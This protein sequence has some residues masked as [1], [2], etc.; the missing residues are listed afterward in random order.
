MYFIPED[1]LDLRVRE[2]KIP[3]DKWY[4]MGLIRLCRGNLIDPSDITAWFVEL[5]NDFEL[6]P[7]K[8]GY[9]RYSACHPFDRPALLSLLA[10]S[11][12]SLASSLS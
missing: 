12:P 2:D 5:M 1:L 7:Y 4:S 6:Y 3:Y 9:D 11:V 8:I 10:E